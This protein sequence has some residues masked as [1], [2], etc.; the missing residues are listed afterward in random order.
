V[1]PAVALLLNQLA[2]GIIFNLAQLLRIYGAFGKLL[3]RDFIASGRKKLPT[4]SARNGA[5]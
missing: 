1:Q 3:T 4:I 5:C 2:D